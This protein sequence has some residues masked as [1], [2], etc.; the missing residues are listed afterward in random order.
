[1]AVEGE[2]QVSAYEFLFEYRQL[3]LRIVCSFC[4]SSLW[5]NIYVIVQDI[6][7]QVTNELAFSTNPAFS[8]TLRL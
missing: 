6:V 1:M 7:C 2:D 4:F 3:A 5:V 8:D